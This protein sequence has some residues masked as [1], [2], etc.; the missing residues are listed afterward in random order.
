[1]LVKKILLSLAVA[2]VFV[3]YSLHT[4]SE[5]SGLKLAPPTTPSSST[6]N[7]SGGSTSTPP[8]TS[9]KYKDGTYTGTVEDAFY[10]YVQV[11]ATIQNG[12]ITDIQYLQRPSDNP[13]TRAINDQADPMLVQEA[14]QSQSAQ[15]DTI[16]GASDTSMAFIQSLT[17]A[18]SHA[19]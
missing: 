6:S 5:G 18:L 16:T 15:V 19:G 13:T 10:G 8:A 7:T 17:A 1:M 11:Q 3:V 2:V 9:G 14:I 4:R 12:K